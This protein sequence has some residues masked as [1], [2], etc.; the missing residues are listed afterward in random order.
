[1]F[2]RLAKL[3]AERARGE[4]GFTLI[5]L[6][7]VVVI[8]G[9]LI[10]VAIPLYLNYRKGANDKAA[11]S[12]LRNAINVLEQCNTDNSA[13]PAT[14]EVSSAGVITGTCSTQSIKL[15]SGSEMKYASTTP[16]AS[17]ILATKNTGGSKYYCY[18][19]SVGGAVKTI[20]VA[21]YDATP[22]TC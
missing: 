9:I 13:Y 8:I 6:L 2:N 17:Y 4:H 21:A 1:M 3:R 12:D 20:L 22:P 19:S 11:Q 16:F 14:A 5:E 15:S 18:N 10:A 7:V